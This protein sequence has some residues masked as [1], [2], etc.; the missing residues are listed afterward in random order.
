VRPELA[1]LSALL[2]GHRI[3]SNRGEPAGRW[4]LT[5]RD[6]LW[7]ALAA[8]PWLLLMMWNTG[9]PVPATVMAKRNYFAEGCLP[10]DFRLA[11]VV[12]SLSRF[13]Q[14]MGVLVFAAPLLV[15]SRAGRLMVLFAC[16][17]LFA[18][19]DSL[20]G[21][22]DHY[23]QRYLYVLVPAMLLGPASATGA[24][25]RIL[26]S[27]GLVVIGLVAVEAATQVAPRWRQHLRYVGFTQGELA[28]T[29]TWLNDNLPASSRVLVHDAG[30]VGF[31]GRFAIVDL[32]GLKTP[33]TRQAHA[34]LTWP[35]CGAARGAAV[36][37][38]A[39]RAHITHL[40]VLSGW[41]AAYRISAA[42]TSA[43]WRVDERFRGAYRVY[44]VAPPVSRADGVEAPP[45]L[46]GTG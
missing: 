33:S 10:A 36:V 43:G 22:L 23:E 4:R 1:L 41:D 6:L 12:R 44:E 18:Y 39:S 9:A 8:A 35:S 42:L 13:G 7:T 5:Q 25:N 37:Q 16:G 17:L 30:Y 20:P 14:T 34:E 46:A 27:A 40:V 32:V 29:T 11:A 31:A 45:P 19:Y 28:R 15:L 21:A 38:I 26:R 2:L 24:S 3:L